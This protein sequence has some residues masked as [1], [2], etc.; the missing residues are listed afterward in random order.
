ML[1]PASSATAAVTKNPASAASM[2]AECVQTSARSSVLE[3]ARVLKP[4]GVLAVATEYILAGPDSP[5]AFQPKDIRRLFDVPGLSLVDSLDES[6]YRRYDTAVVDLNKNM[7]Q[8]PHMVVEIDGTRFTSV[9][10][11]LMKA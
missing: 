3:M 7:D 1:W 9:M 4:G 6:V 8:R 2:S 10:V 11:F 5:E